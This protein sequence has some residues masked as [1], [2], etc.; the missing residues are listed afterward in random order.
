[1]IHQRL[2][3]R[4]EDRHGRSSRGGISGLPCANS[5]ASIGEA[6]YYVFLCSC[7]VMVGTGWYRVVQCAKP[8]ACRGAGLQLM[9]LQHK[10]LASDQHCCSALAHPRQRKPHSNTIQGILRGSPWT[11]A[12]ARFVTKQA[13]AL[14]PFHPRYLRL[15]KCVLALC[16]P[17]LDA[18]HPRCCPG[19]PNKHVQRANRLWQ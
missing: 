8:K 19:Q 5:F 7:T 18:Q 14:R 15:Q 9:R 13:T 1:M 12:H 4:R 6:C 16:H 2:L 11:A 3:A 10:N 17:G